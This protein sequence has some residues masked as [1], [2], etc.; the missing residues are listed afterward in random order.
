MGLG[1]QGVGILSDI[2]APAYGQESLRY[3]LMVF[4]TLNIWCAWHYF[5]AARTLTH[6][7]QA[8]LPQNA[9]PEKASASA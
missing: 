3:S 7:M 2:F 6:D 5:L 1:P 9:S 8:A 4:S